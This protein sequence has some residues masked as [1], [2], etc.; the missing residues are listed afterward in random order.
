MPVSLDWYMQP[1]IRRPEPADLSL[2]SSITLRST[3]ESIFS[4]AS[5]PLSAEAC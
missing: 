4:K 5:S 2:M 1:R 3:I